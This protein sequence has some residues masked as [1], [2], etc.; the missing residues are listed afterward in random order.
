M[1]QIKEEFEELTAEQIKQRDSLNLDFL[2][3]AKRP[4]TNKSGIRFD[5]EKEGGEIN[6]FDEVAK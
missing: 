3:H 6:L 4:R 1:K 5:G 2:R